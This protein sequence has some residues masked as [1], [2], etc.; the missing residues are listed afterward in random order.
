M[1]VNKCYRGDDG[2]IA[3]GDLDVIEHLTSSLLLITL[4]FLIL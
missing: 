3:V 1:R 4:V 2:N